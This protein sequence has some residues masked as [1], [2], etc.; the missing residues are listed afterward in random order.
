MAR[1]RLMKTN[2]TSG[3]IS[4]DLLGRGDLSA[5][6]NGAAALRNVKIDPTGGVSR[7]PGLRYIAD[8]AGTGRLVAFEF[9][10]EQIYLLCFTDQNIA[11][12][13]DD[14]K[15]VDVGAPWTEVQIR[16]INWTQSADTLLIVHPDVPPKKLV[17]EG[18]TSW[19]LEDWEYHK[20]DEDIDQPYYKFA[21]EDVTLTP[22][23]TSGSIT[24]TASG[25][26][27]VDDHVGAR[28]RL[29]SKSVE[30]TAVSSPTSATAQVKEGLSGTGA[31]KDW[32]EQ[33]FSDA[34]GYPVSCC[35]HQDRLVIGGSRDL[36][37]RLWFSR[38]SDL[39]N[40]DLGTAEDDEA[41]EFAILSDQV[42]AIRAC[43]SGRHLQVFTS[44]AEWMV[45]GEPLTPG[46]IQLR[47]QTR[48]GSPIDRTIPPRDVDGAT[49]YVSRSGKDLREFLFA[50]VE[51]AYQSNDLAVLAKHVMSGPLDMDFEKTSRIMYLVMDDGRIGSVTVFRPEKVTAWAMMETDGA[52]ESVATVGEDVY[53]IVNRSGTWRIEKFDSTLFT[54]SGLSGCEETPSATWS[55]LEHLEGK[56]VFV[57]A[58]GIVRQP[59]TIESGSL[60]LEDPASTVEIGLPYSH[61]I[62]PLPL[63]AAGGSGIAQG[64]AVRLVRATF[65]LVETAALSVDVGQGL[66]S[67]PFKKLGPGSLDSPIQPVTGDKTIRAL[68][69]TRGEPKPLW[70]VEQDSPLPCNIASVL[71]E[72]SSNA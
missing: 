53:C 19:N 54:D 7:R 27:F 28:F 18:P 31:T 10:T 14:A 55:G 61:R 67:I 52:F 17:R 60:T 2:F 36:P 33:S 43:F 26:V 62:E 63:V 71:T 21:K 34:R 47:R 29:N 46:N 65:R 24:L 68:G 56:E 39:F 23:A 69:W 8:A 3:E 49:L 11:I 15:I 41:I 9:N 4:T 64:S 40:F 38:S 16:Q 32:E 42:N 50:D 72:V 44:G 20:T 1:L 6:E 59:Q 48:I 22:S 30:I 66:K 45:T 51:Q 12:Y 13:A 37:N 35:F 25:D 58:D 70:Q 5:Y 57:V